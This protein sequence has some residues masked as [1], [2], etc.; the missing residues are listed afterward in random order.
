MHHFYSQITTLVCIHFKVL[1]L[2]YNSLQYSNPLTFSNFTPFC[3]PAIPDYPS[4]SPFLDP[5]SLLISCLQPNHIHHCTT[6]LGWPATWTPLFLYPHNQSQTIIFTWLLY[7]SSGFPFK[8][9]HHPIIRLPTLALNDTCL[10][11]LFCLLWLLE[12]GP[13]RTLDYRFDNPSDSALVNNLMPCA[14]L[15]SGALEVWRLRLR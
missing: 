4:V 12:I 11:Q 8:G 2:T 10:K 14:W 5:W 6:S 7:H 3:H 13:E 9:G 15:S 1:S